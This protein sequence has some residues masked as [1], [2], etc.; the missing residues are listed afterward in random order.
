M[1]DTTYPSNII[2]DPQTL[3]GPTQAAIK[4]F[5]PRANPFAKQ[6][7]E[8]LR[9][10]FIDTRQALFVFGAPDQ[11]T[12]AKANLHAWADLGKAL[13]GIFDEEVRVDRTHFCAGEDSLEDLTAEYE[14]L[15]GSVNQPV[16]GSTGS[17]ERAELTSPTSMPPR[18]CIEVR[19]GG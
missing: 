18:F 19:N 11:A 4:R 1:A 16:E 17:G 2:I 15:P 3:L 9:L 14:G 7:I 6:I 13:R 5:S 10:L 12:L 8:G